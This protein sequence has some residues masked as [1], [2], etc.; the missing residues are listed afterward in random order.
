[1]HVISIISNHYLRQY[2]LDSSANFWRRAKSGDPVLWFFLVLHRRP[3]LFL[4]LELALLI[5]PSVY[6]YQHLLT[7]QPCPLLL[8]SPGPVIEKCPP[9]LDSFSPE[10][11]VVL[12]WYILLLLL[13]I[14]F[15]IFIFIHIIPTLH[16][17]THLF[18][19]L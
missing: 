12:I 4:F 19:S 17:Y 18:F 15:A 2:D 14:F 16:F 5:F 9:A 6:A 7:G 1:M 3:Y 11:I 13:L 8:G 10:F